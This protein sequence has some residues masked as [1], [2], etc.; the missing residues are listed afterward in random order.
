M[1]DLH[2]VH[3]PTLRAYCRCAFT[4]CRA[5]CR[6]ATSRCVAAQPPPH[7]RGP[8]STPMRLNL[9]KLP[10]RT[11]W[12]MRK[13]NRS[14]NELFVR[15][16]YH[17]WVAPPFTADYDFLHSHFTIVVEG[18]SRCGMA[19]SLLLPCC[20]NPPG[21]QKREKSATGGCASQHFT[22]DH[23]SSVLRCMGSGLKLQPI[24]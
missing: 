13:E 11:D 9:P 15:E 5:I 21:T 8:V 24:S 19:G 7:L 1:V 2:V 16:V 12:G 18:G 22:F 3:E 4:V 14:V 23:A 6:L 17:R 20:A 10:L